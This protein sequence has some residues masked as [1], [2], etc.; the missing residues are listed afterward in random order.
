MV[1]AWNNPG[2][3]QEE[4]SAG[5]DLWICKKYLSKEGVKQ[6]ANLTMSQWPPCLYKGT[7]PSFTFRSCYS[8]PIPFLGKSEKTNIPLRDNHKA[9]IHGATKQE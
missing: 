5:E 2:R 1:S 6:Q 4:T 3:V 7:S 9:F 8:V